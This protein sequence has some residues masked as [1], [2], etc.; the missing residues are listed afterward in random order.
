VCQILILRLRTLIAVIRHSVTLI[1]TIEMSEIQ[2]KLRR[3]ILIPIFAMILLL[4]AAGTIGMYLLLDRQIHNQTNHTVE[5]LSRLYDVIVEDDAKEF[6]GLLKQFSANE[7]FAQFWL[8]GDRSALLAGAKPIYDTLNKNHRITHFY[9]HNPDR[10][11]FLRI[12]KPTRHGDI[13][14]RQTLLSAVDTGKPTHGLELGLFGGFVLRVIQPW[15]INK[16]L[17]GYLEIGEEIDYIVP[18]LSKAVGVDLLVLL[19]KNFLNRQNWEQFYLNNSNANNWNRFPNH[20]VNYQGVSTIPPVIKNHLLSN[21]LIEPN[22]IYQFK[23]NGN[24]YH[25]INT[26]LMDITNLN[27]GELIILKNTT[28]GQSRLRQAIAVLIS[29][30]AVVYF[31]IFLGFYGYLGR[32]ENKIIETNR[33]LESRIDAH[34][35]TE[36]ELKARTRDLEASNKELESYSY[37]I[38]HDL[39]TPLRS[40]MSFSQILNSETSE[41]LSADE[42]DSLQRIITA[43]KRMASL[44]NDILKLSRVSRSGMTYSKVDLSRLAKASIDRIGESGSARRVN[45]K[46]QD[47]LTTFGDI[48]LLT[49]L[50]ENLLENSYKYTRST[51][52][53]VIE[54]GVTTSRNVRAFYVRDNGIGFSMSHSQKLFQPFQRLHSNNNIKGT[55]VGL[56]MVQR[57][58]ERHNGKIWFESEE[59]QGATF[60]FVLDAIVST[61]QTNSVDQL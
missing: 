26:P 15:Y 39:R 22:S 21:G 49:L 29:L 37:T 55:G 50:L 41:R 24:F 28:A 16:Q 11:V 51:E 48:K 45:W 47:D 30:G 12:H 57:I 38:A 31:I 58:I 18:L 13:I 27:V 1:Y 33:Q 3:R 25:A 60:Y 36:N 2:L 32:L 19:D 20:V 17:V 42:N 7:R 46:I 54:F 56:A 23:L 34:K 9:F 44:I 5:L 4:I 14:Q 59:G 43:G 35:L 10:S 52:N 61:T 53:A 40:V 6:Y 8:E